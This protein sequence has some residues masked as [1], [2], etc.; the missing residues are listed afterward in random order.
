M[1]NNMPD[2]QTILNN[3]SEGCVLLV[4]DD[5]DVLYSIRDLLE[6]EG[7]FNIET[8]MDAVEALEK[9]DQAK[10]DIA[11][12]DIRLGKSNGLELIAEM[13]YKAPAINCIMM[14]AYRDVDYA[15]K[16]LRAGADDYLFKPI[17]PEKLI[18]IV[19]DI[20]HQNRIEEVKS[21][22]ERNINTILDHTSGFIFI[23]S[24]TGNCLEA[25]YTALSFI[26]QDW[27][28]I[29]GK[30]F[31][32]TPWWQNSDS[33]REQIRQAVETA[34]VGNPT[35]LEVALTDRNGEK[36]WYE[37]SLKPVFEN[38]K[39]VA[40][41]I[42]QGSDLTKYKN[43][44]QDLKKLSLYDPLTGLANR[45]LLLEHLENSLARANRSSQKFSVIFID[46]D[47]FKAV[48]DTLGHYAGDELL[49]NIGQC[50]KSCLRDE[51]I[52]ARV[53][54]DEFVAVLS[55]ESDKE[56]TTKVANRLMQSIASLFYNLGDGKTVSASLGIAIYPNDGED[57]DTILKNADAAMYIAKSNGKNCFRYFNDE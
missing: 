46:L 45:T 50:L 55:S 24:P 49:V 17:D 33:D 48:N 32:Q 36:A 38:E 19:D 15:V 21:R 16:A 43:M 51:D 9:A 6:M 56:G 52:I 41:I 8:A 22:N 54:G 13:K 1:T 30:P 12:I 29:K 25:G 53:G 34:A 23:L 3:R 26:D 11:L 10:P 37:F 31:F 44:E 27:D 39:Q 57:A 47:H 28:E 35:T 7:G 14:T 4:D 20:Y 18:T 42:V 40:L 5:Q 2:Q